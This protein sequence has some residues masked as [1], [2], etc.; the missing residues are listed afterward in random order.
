MFLLLKMAAATDAVAAWRCA[1]PPTHCS[2]LYVVSDRWHAGIVLR[3]GE[4]SARRIPEIRDFSGFEMIEFSWGDRDYFPHPD[5]GVS[6]ALRAAFWS[7]GSVLHLVGFNGPVEIFYR[8][9]TIT[10]FHLSRPAFERLIAFL[11]KTFERPDPALPAEARP[12]L[13]A[14]SRFYSAVGKFSIARTCNTWVAEAFRYV[15]LPIDAPSVITSGQLNAKIAE[16]AAR[17]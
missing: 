8:G 17:K 5:P 11:A 9:A 14:Y 10:E 3:L 4:V 16:F 2:R 13:F 1:E 6:A 15:G 7:R 12:G